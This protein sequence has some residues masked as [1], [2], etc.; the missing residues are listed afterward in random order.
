MRARLLIAAA[1]AAVA[2]TAGPPAEACACGVAL[3]ASVTRERALIVDRGGREEIIASFDLRSE[4]SGRGAILFP[5]PADPEVE[6]VREGD[7]LAYLDRAT[8]PKPDPDAPDTAAG[9][10]AR[11]GAVDVIGRATIGGYDVSRLRAR[12]PEALDA[13]LDR[14]GYTLP[15]GAEP[16]LADYVAEDWRY[17]AVRLARGAAEGRLK[18]LSIAFDTDKPVYPMRLTQLGTSPVDVTLYVLAAGARRVKGLDVTYDDAVS[19]L[20]PPPPQELEGLFG[21]GGT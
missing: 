1:C 11:R 6:E 5:V 13:W 12:D 19:A 21:K 14:N 18:P 15:A 10:G 20:D 9:A 2:L 4:G 3:Q 17:V 16:I 7:P 8:A